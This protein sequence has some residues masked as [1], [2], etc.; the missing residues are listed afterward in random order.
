MPRGRKRTAPARAVTSQRKNK[1]VR[2]GPATPGGTKTHSSSREREESSGY[3]GD[4]TDHTDEDTNGGLDLGVTEVDDDDDE[5]GNDDDDDDDDDDREAELTR[6][7][8]RGLQEAMERTEKRD[9]YAKELEKCIDEEERRLEGLLEAVVRERESEAEE[10]RSR[11]SL[12]IGTALAPTGTKTSGSAAGCLSDTQK[13]CLEDVSSDR[14]PLYNKCQVLLQCTKSLLQEYDNLAAYISK[15]EVPP[16]PAEMWEEDCAETRR[17]I[18]IGAEASQAEINKLLACKDDAQKRGDKGESAP[19]K[20]RKRGRR[21]RAKVFEKDEH[22]QAML[23]IGKEKDP[24]PTKEPYGWGKTAFQMVK[25]MK[26]LAK[27]L[28]VERK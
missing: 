17:V 7:A 24:F 6:A 2:V 25:G 8:L 4:N 26:T 19:S 28:P 22:L 5:F 13:L 9:N 3:A 12:L 20:G 10:F 15:L 1:R 14:H 16:D 18:G 23:K 21:A 11:F 27:A